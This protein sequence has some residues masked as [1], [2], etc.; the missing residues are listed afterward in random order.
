MP[1]HVWEQNIYRL[2][3]HH[4]PQLVASDTSKKCIP[5][6]P[7]KSALLSALG[8]PAHSECVWTSLEGFLVIGHVRHLVCCILAFVQGTFAFLDVVYQ[9]NIL[10]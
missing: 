1:C 4:V 2:R 10:Y 7:E 8:D 6:S 9:W 3:M 5:S